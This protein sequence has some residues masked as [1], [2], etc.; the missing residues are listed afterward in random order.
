MRA[1]TSL[2]LI[3]HHGTRNV[4]R[5]VTRNLRVS[6]AI[7]SQ[8]RTT[9]AGLV[10]SGAGIVGFAAQAKEQRATDPDTTF[11]SE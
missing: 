7:R 11:Q 4:T 9:V 1:L 2:N 10:L 6:R 5:N 3:I 8:P